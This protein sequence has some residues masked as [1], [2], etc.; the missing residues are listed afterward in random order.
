[1]IGRIASRIGD[2]GLAAELSRF[3]IVGV[4]ATLVYFVVASVLVLATPI[5]ATTASIVAYCC[6]IPVSFLG[7]SRFTFRVGQTRAAHLLRFA[8]V[9]VLGLSISYLSIVL[10]SSLSLHPI[11]GVVCGTILVPI[12]SFIVMN[13]WVFRT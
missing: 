11:A 5:Q 10:A 12:M 2:D 8:L 1:M 4:V 3:S 9:T 6:G 7:Q 13:S